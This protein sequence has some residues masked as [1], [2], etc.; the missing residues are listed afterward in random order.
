MRL[1]PCH[2]SCLFIIFLILGVG[3]SQIIAE[4][5]YSKAGKFHIDA[6]WDSDGNKFIITVKN[7]GPTT[8]SLK[9]KSVSDSEV[10]IVYLDIAITDLD[11]PDAI[12]TV[13]NNSDKKISIDVHKI[14]RGKFYIYIRDKNNNRQLEVARRTSTVWVINHIYPGGI[15]IPR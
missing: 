8:A 6:T 11:N 1:D 10:V 4:T 7:D 5:V 14:T 9:S 15:I 2:K 12:S 3:F 13:W